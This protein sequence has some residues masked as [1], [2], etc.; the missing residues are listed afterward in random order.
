MSRILL[1]AAASALLSL[2][3]GCSIHGKWSL[4]SVDPS[5]ARRDFQY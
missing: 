1:I 2:S 4:A 5:A 3:A